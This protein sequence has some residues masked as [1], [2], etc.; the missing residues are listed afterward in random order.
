MSDN[1]SKLNPKL[2][3]FLTVFLTVNC[4]FVEDFS[5]QMESEQK[6]ETLYDKVW[7]G[8]SILCLKK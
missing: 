7:L 6:G 1:L 5:E 3:P 2:H 4:F 8:T